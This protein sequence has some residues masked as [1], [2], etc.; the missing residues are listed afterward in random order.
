MPMPG[1][2]SP[3]HFEATAAVYPCIDQ[4]RLDGEHTIQSLPGLFIRQGPR[5]KIK[6]CNICGQKKAS[7]IQLTGALHIP[8]GVRPATLPAIDPCT[9]FINLWVVRQSASGN[10]KLGAG[11]I[12]IEIS[13]IKMQRESQMRLARVGLQVESRI[14]SLL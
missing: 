4:A 7:R 11:V 1:V 10:S 9:H 6:S 14:N 13:P 5:T 8:Y 12:V 2:A 3:M